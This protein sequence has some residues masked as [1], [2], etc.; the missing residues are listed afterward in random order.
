M[1]NCARL[2]TGKKSLALILQAGE[3]QTVSHSLTHVL[4]V[5]NTEGGRSGFIYKLVP[6]ETTI[7]WLFYVG[8]VASNGTGVVIV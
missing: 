7:F 2:Y 5:H 4:S 1:R 6:G 3:T 8:H